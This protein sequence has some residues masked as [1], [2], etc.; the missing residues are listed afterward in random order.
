MATFCT[1]RDEPRQE[2]NNQ[3]Q[4]YT[5]LNRDPR[6]T[7]ETTRRNARGAKAAAAHLLVLVILLLRDESLVIIGRHNPR[8]VWL[9]WGED[10]GA[11]GDAADADREA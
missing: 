5:N 10:K 2:K 1:K 9:E 11:D 7:S 6:S 8:V 3:L 4:K